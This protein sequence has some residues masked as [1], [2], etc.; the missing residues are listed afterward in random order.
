MEFEYPSNKG[1]TIYSKSGCLNCTK[2]KNLLKEQKVT[3]NIVDCDEYIIENKELFLHFI[4]ELSH[5]D[6]KEFP[7]VFH[8]RN[9]IGGYKSVKEYIAK[10]LLS[11]EDNLDF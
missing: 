6:I 11:F 7:I 4:K 8:E 9:F 5:G 10:L 3:F 2:V 1:F